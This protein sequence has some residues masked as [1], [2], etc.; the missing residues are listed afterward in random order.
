MKDTLKALIYL[1]TPQPGH[2]QAVGQDTG[3]GGEE[4]HLWPRVHEVSSSESAD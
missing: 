4:H 3:P 2:V 1:D